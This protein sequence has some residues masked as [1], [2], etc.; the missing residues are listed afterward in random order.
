M[1]EASSR[2]LLSSPVLRFTAEESARANKDWKATCGPHSI[3]A[4]CGIALDQVREQLEYFG[5]Y[6]GWM[7]PT[8]VQRVL[9]RLQKPFR[10]DR[11]NIKTSELCNGINRIQ[12]EGPWLKPGV[13]A[14]VAYRHTHWIAHFNGWVLCTACLPSEW[15]TVEDWRHH[16]LEV[17]PATPFHITHHYEME[18]ATG[19]P[20][21]GQ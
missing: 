14:R 3:A 12:W 8:Q 18:N 16:H 17:E 9:L 15:I 21:G 10:L 13:P 4:A 1:S 20:G 7:S 11:W 5:D 6:K 2:P 19:Q